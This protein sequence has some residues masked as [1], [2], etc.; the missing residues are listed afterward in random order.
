[1][2][3]KTVFPPTFS[4]FR[5]EMTAET[6]SLTFPEMFFL[7]DFLSCLNYSFSVIHG[8]H[9]KKFLSEP[10]EIMNVNSHMFCK[11]PY[12]NIR[13]SFTILQLSF[14]S[15]TP[16]ISHNVCRAALTHFYK[17]RSFLPRWTSSKNSG[18][19]WFHN[20]WDYFIMNGT[21]MPR[22]I[23]MSSLCVCVCICRHLKRPVKMPGRISTV[24][25]S[26]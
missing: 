25:R 9:K 2:Q 10:M 7:T 4:F 26:C 3:D 23:K 19:N 18:W 13:S 12:G 1:M 24:K 11:T 16:V 8:K 17:P 22:S 5:C 21:F 20:E 14:P 6:V 15:F